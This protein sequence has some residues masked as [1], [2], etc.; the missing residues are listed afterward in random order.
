MIKELHCKFVRVEDDWNNSFTIPYSSEMY[1]IILHPITAEHLSKPLRVNKQTMIVSDYLCE[2]VY[3][4]IKD[5]IP[6]NDSDWLID[7]IVSYFND[8]TI[9]PFSKKIM[10]K[11]YSVLYALHFDM[12]GYIDQGKA[13]N[14]C[15]MDYNSYEYDTILL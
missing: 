11:I 13:R 14:I 6:S 5:L 9:C 15:E 12:F 1:K 8:R 10:S 4:N 7:L 2:I 3:E